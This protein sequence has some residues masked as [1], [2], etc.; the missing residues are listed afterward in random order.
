MQISFMPDPIFGEFR[1]P[2]D[3]SSIALFQ[4]NLT[5]GKEVI[6]F[7]PHLREFGIYPIAYA[8]KIAGGELPHTHTFL[9]LVIAVAGRGVHTNGTHNVEISR[10]DIV[11][12]SNT[13]AHYFSSCS[14]DFRVVDI[15]FLPSALGYSDTSLDDARVADHYALLVP[16]ADYEAHE[17]FTVVHPDEDTFKRIAWYAFHML[18]TFHT[19]GEREIVL[20]ALK[21][22]LIM[23]VPKTETGSANNARFHEILAYIREHAHGD[24]TSASVAEH[25]GFS[26]AYFSTIFNRISGDTLH[27]YVNGLRV[28]RAKELIERT[29]LPINRIAHEVGYHNISHF[30]VAFKRVLRR[31]PGAFRLKRKHLDGR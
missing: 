3:A 30:N 9:E 14:E 4:A 28:R 20:N 21:N 26:A 19:G 23:A 29:T 6:S 22:V 15:C 24:I 31:S 27:G 7:K 12:T 10:G 5:R 1:I 16:F 18:E 17:H 13:S 11:F 2:D 8:P 25:F